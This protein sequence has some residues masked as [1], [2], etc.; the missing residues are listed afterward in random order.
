MDLFNSI[1]SFESF[2][3]VIGDEDGLGGCNGG[4]FNTLSVKSPESQL[5]FVTIIALELHYIKV[6][7]KLDNLFF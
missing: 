5:I 1:P 3:S 6:I 4:S 2:S 7:I